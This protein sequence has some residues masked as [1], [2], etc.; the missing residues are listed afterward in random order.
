MMMGLGQT[1]ETASTTNT[2]G[3]WFTVFVIGFLAV[4]TLKPATKVRHPVV[5]KS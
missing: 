2:A 4:Y 3:V 5:E 1:T